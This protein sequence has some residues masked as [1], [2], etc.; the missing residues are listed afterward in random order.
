MQ[1]AN[2]AKKAITEEAGT[3]S[4]LSQQCGKKTNTV[5][6]LIGLQLAKPLIYVTLYHKTSLKCHFFQIEIKT[7]SES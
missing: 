3:T 1:N 4:N 5:N 6:L 7:S 2:T